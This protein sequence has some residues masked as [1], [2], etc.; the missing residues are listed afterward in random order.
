M[1]A[2]PSRPPFVLIGSDPPSESLST[3][4]EVLGL[5]AAAEAQLLEL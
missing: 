5:P 1:Y 4:G 2:S 3:G